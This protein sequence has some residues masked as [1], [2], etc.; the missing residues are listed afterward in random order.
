MSDS[1]PTDEESE[2]DAEGYGVR[3]G[4]FSD[5]WAGVRVPVVGDVVFY[6]LPSGPRAGEPRPAFVVRETEEPMQPVLCTPD[7]GAQLSSGFAVLRPSGYSPRGSKGAW[8]WS[9]RWST[10]MHVDV[11]PETGRARR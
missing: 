8:S 4:T 7:D 9:W 10:P 5:P 11:D 1:F 2:R 3:C 6:V